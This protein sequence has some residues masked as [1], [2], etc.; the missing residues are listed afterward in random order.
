MDLGRQ[1]LNQGDPADARKVLGELVELTENE[2]LAA[3]A[4]A[5]INAMPQEE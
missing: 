5:L 1:L 3:E 4:T 2:A